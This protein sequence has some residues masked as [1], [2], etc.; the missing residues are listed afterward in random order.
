MY[1]RIDRLRTL[2]TT[3]HVDV[4]QNLN[5]RE[6]RVWD[7]QRDSESVWKIMHHIVLYTCVGFI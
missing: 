2:L 1:V 5:T 3:S 7:Y 4:A 6:N